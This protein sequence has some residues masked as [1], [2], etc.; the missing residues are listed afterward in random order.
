MGEVVKCGFIADP[1]ILEIIESDPEAIFD[2]S[3]EVIAE[4]I[5]R[6]IAVKARVVSMDLHESGPREFLNYGHTLA[7]AVEKLEHFDF[8][9][10]EA[11][12]I[13][14]V[15]A[16]NLARQ[17][18]LLTEEDVLR[19]EHDFASLGLPTHYLD[20]SIEDL[21]NVMLSDKKVRAGVLRFVLLDGIENPVTLPVSP[22][23]VRAC[24]ESMGMKH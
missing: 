15:F 2:P 3:S 19:H 11:V 23:E 10:G 14:C 20:A 21:L 22:D 12:A 6:S 8:R 18:G 9:H 16:A 1:R 24:A 4:L 5:E 17:R 13:G 7:H